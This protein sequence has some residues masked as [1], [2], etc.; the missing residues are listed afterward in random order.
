MTVDFSSHGFLLSAAPSHIPH[1]G[2]KVRV[3]V[4]WPV[5]LGGKT[6]LQFIVRGKV[7]RAGRSNFV[8]LFEHY[9]FHTRKR[10]RD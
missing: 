5:H 8:L 10:T 7:V 3:V 4:E 2:A 6:P 9:E 1:P